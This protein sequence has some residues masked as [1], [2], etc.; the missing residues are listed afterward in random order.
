MFAAE[1][2]NVCSGSESRNLAPVLSRLEKMR[3]V[4][5]MDT[6]V[7]PEYFAERAERTIEVLD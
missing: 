7:R 2:I 4:S 5:G 1:V 3:E 6:L